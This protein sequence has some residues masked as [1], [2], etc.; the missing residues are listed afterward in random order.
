MLEN[1]LKELGTMLVKAGNTI[2]RQ[3]EEIERLRRENNALKTRQFSMREFLLTFHGKFNLIIYD[4]K[5][6]EKTYYKSSTQ[7]DNIPYINSIND[8]GILLVSIVSNAYGEPLLYISL[9]D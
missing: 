2:E 6:N 5:T 4:V 7:L 3:K 8:R 9:D 1:N